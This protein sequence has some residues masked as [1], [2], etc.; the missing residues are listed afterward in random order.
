MEM[1]STEVATDSS[2]V[3][4][5]D[6]NQSMNLSIFILPISS[7]NV[8]GIPSRMFILI[9]TTQESTDVT[10][11]TTPQYPVTEFSPTPETETTTLPFSVTVITD[12]F[13]MSL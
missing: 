2:T 12:A 3:T 6:D 7:M 8:F 1:T 10:G 13:S 11:A 5:P 9:G 4:Q